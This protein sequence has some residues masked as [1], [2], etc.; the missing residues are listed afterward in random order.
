MYLLCYYHMKSHKL[1]LEHFICF[2][3]HSV[4][5]FFLFPNTVGETKCY[6]NFCIIKIVLEKILGGSNYTHSFSPFKNSDVLE[7]GG[8]YGLN[9]WL[10]LVEEETAC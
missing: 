2:I 10:K 6:N 3:V 1:T 5:F 7:N 9:L 8:I 4:F